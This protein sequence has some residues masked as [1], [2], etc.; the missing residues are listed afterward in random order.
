MKKLSIL[1][2]VFIFALCSFADGTLYLIKDSNKIN[3][4]KEQYPLFLQFGNELIIKG[5]KD[6]IKKLKIDNPPSKDFYGELFIMKARDPKAS[7]LLNESTEVIYMY[8]GFVLFSAKEGYDVLT[9]DHQTDKIQIRKVEFPEVYSSFRE[10]NQV[11]F[12][13]NIEDVLDT[14]DMERVK[15]NLERLVAYKT[16]YTFTDEYKQCASDMKDLLTEIGYETKIQEFTSWYGK[17]DNV[18]AFKQGKTDK[19]ILVVG[20][21]DSTSEKAKTLAPGGDDNGSGSVGVIELAYI[22][23]DIDTNLSVEF[24]LFGGEEN[25]LLGSYGYARDNELENI[26]GVLNMDMIAFYK[27]TPNTVYI[28]TYEFA[29]DFI[30]LVADCGKLYNDIE[31]E[32]SFHAFGSDHLPFLKKNIPAVLTI[33]KEWDLNPHYHKTTDDLRHI[34]FDYMEKFIRMNT[35]TLL[36]MDKKL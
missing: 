1:L 3:S 6:T 25:G 33:E 11:D 32:I 20:H 12:D 30:Y 17:G 5:S 28:E 21:L 34:S 9:K 31:T 23:K 7:D 2:L 35:A 24:I 16:R 29:R 13:Q 18:I 36:E 27:N 8:N 4:I 26:V 19:K 10:K 15:A 14:I 22:L